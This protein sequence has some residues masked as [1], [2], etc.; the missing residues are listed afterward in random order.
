MIR[1][2]SSFFLVEFQGITSTG[3]ISQ[4]RRALFERPLVQFCCERHAALPSV[5]FPPFYKV[6]Q[7]PSQADKRLSFRLDFRLHQSG[8]VP[9]PPPSWP[10]PPGCPGLAR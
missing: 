7:V 6:G 1:A 4:L 10:P 3:N 2:E 9:V 5:G 8:S